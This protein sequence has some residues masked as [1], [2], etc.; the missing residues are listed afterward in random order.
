[1]NIRELS[2]EPR[3][4]VGTGA[5]GRLRGEASGH[6]LEVPAHSHGA[7]GE[8]FPV[9]CAHRR[10]RPSTWAYPA[11]SRGSASHQKSTASSQN[12]P[13]RPG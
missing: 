5:V 12:F 2:V 11:R 7:L 4:A 10:R 9:Q 3:E 8:D 1:M 6:P 13:K